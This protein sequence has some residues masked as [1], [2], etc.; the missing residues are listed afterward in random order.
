MRESYRPP[1]MPRQ[2]SAI[3]SWEASTP[4]EV[5]QF[6]GIDSR[7]P[8]NY[9]GQLDRP[10]MLDD[11][12]GE[13]ARVLGTLTNVH[14]IFEAARESNRRKL[15]ASATHKTRAEDLDAIKQKIPAY[16]ALK[17]Q[18]EALSRA[19]AS[20]ETARGLERSIARLTEAIETH[21]I[22]RSQIDS[23]T[24]LAS[25]AVPSDEAIVSA[26]QR[27]ERFKDALRER[28]DAAA[29]VETSQKAYDALEAQQS[30]LEAE[31]DELIGQVGDDLAGWIA[32]TAAV[33]TLDD[34]QEF[35]LLDEAIRVFTLYITTK[36]EQQ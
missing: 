27:L 29:A 3:P 33:K 12:G 10:F 13:V 9:A 2:S 6:L 21:D 16:R 22:A 32:A 14:V 31:R 1:I 25:R 26:H 19:E 35:L 8:I 24:E 23:L 15:A 4:E 5:S 36:A 17:A 18:D 11:S 28:R 30:A 7:D 20:I 34:G